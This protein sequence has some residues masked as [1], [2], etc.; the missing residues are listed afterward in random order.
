MSD[1]SLTGSSAALAAGRRLENIESRRI[2]AKP[3]QEESKA[4]LSNSLLARLFGVSTHE[5]EAYV[6]AQANAPAS[7]TAP[8]LADEVPVATPYVAAVLTEASPQSAPTFPA[9]EKGKPATVQEM[10]D[11]M[12]SRGIQI[13]LND[14]AHFLYGSVGVNEDLRNF[15][16]ILNSSNPF[17]ANNQALGYMFN[18][19]GFVHPANQVGK[20]SGREAMSAGNLV[21]DNHRLYATTPDGAHVVPVRLPK[22]GM[23]SGGLARYAITDEEAS[24]LLSN[25]AVSEKVKGL[26]EP[27][28]GTG[29]KPEV[30]EKY[31]VQ[32]R[33]GAGWSSAVSVGLPFGR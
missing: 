33:P 4:G 8:A 15:D 31:V 17:E 21:V 24:A 14:A 28:V 18:D 32:R 27:Y 22:G 6:A 20:V 16:A 9:W 13:N 3:L 19:P 10:V 1:V 30:A 25:P 7:A 26:L 2:D 23:H 29:Y 12:V 11:F 5:I